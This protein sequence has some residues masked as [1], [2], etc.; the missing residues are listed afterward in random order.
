[1]LPNQQLPLNSR[2]NLPLPHRGI[3]IS[4]ATF[5]CDIPVLQSRPRNNH[6]KPLHLYPLIRQYDWNPCWANRWYYETWKPNIPPY[7]CRCKENW[8]ELE[9]KYPPDFSSPENFFRWGWERHNDVSRL[10]SKKPTITF[11]EAYKLWKD[12]LPS[13]RCNLQVPIK[14]VNG[15]ME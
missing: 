5:R 8:Q 11:E 10:H 12:S 14:K 9:D 4:C 15:E 13:T 3:D 1:M 7:G 2:P 6:W